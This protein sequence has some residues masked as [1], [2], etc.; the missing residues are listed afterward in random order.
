MRSSRHTSSN[1][2]KFT[3]FNHKRNLFVSIIKFIT[4]LFL[5]LECYQTIVQV[6]F[7]LAY[8]QALFTIVSQMNKIEQE[9]W[10]KIQTK[11]SKNVYFHC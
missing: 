6:V 11:K 1:S 9:A 8:I 7:N 10:S 5:F 3:L 4:L 2:S